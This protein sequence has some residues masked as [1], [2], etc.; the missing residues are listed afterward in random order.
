VPG[1][2]HVGFVLDP[3]VSRTPVVAPMSAVVHGITVH[4]D[5]TARHRN[6]ASHQAFP[7]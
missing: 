2:A 7:Q 5:T 4:R 1:R 6:T 3:V